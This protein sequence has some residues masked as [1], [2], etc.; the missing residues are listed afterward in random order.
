MVFVEYF[1]PITVETH[2]EIFK[3]ML[4]LELLLLWIA[5]FFVLLI[6]Y[7]VRRLSM[8]SNLRHIVYFIA[9]QYLILTTPARFVIIFF[10]LGIFP[11]QGSFSLFIEID[12]LSEEFKI[13][14]KSKPER[15]SWAKNISLKH[16]KLFCKI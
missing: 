1:R 12:N 15:E 4:S 14:E 13:F 5:I 16:L 10:E 11:I 9:I 6:I 8:H 2:R 7:A 3:F